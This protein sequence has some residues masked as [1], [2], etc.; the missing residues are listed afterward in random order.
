[1]KIFT[2]RAQVAEYIGCSEAT[3]Y[4]MLARGE[5]P[6]PIDNAGKP[7]KN[8]YWTESM[9]SSSKKCFANFSKH[10]SHSKA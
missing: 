4:R 7:K 8:G 10:S 9:L 5:I 1:M 2:S 3:V 6:L